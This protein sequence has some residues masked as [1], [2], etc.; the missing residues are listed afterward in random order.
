MVSWPRGFK[1]GGGGVGLEGGGNGGLMVSKKR[2]ISGHRIRVQ[3]PKHARMRALTHVA[4]KGDLLT[5]L[6]KPASQCWCCP[7]VSMLPQLLP[8]PSWLPLCKVSVSEVEVEAL[9]YKVQKL[10]T[11][12]S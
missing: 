12:P 5:P 7:G 9:R 8:I 1:E 2:V 11:V 4:N 6:H 10:G 3:E